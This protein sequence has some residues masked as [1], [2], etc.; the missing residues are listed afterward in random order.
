MTGD[1]GFY[2]SDADWSAEW[3]APD[4]CSPLEPGAWLLFLLLLDFFI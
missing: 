1:K 3:N 4:P 2:I